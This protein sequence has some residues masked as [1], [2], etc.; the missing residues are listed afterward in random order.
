M[1]F[2]LP[3]WVVVVLAIA[4]ATLAAMA[5][6]PAF[7]NVAGLLNGLAGLLGTTSTIVAL[8]APSIVHAANVQAVVGYRRANP[9]PETVAAE[10]GFARVR[11]LWQLCLFGIAVLVIACATLRAAAPAAQTL[12]QCVVGW[13]ETNVSLSFEAMVISL[14]LKCGGDVLDVIEVLATSADPN[15]AQYKS[16]ALAAK[17]DPAKVGALQMHL[18]ARRHDAGLAQ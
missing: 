18:L 14:A 5:Q 4:T 6:Q 16:A 12:E 8:H 10:R 2:K 15:L 9:T 1:Q 13:A 11:L 7:E 17:A 3:H